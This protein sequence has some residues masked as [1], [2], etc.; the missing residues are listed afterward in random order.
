[1]DEEVDK[2]AL[3]SLANIIKNEHQDYTDEEKGAIRKGKEFY[4]KCK[5]DENFDDLKSPDERVKMKLVHVDGASSGTGVAT[6]VVDGSADECA[7][8]EIISLN[9]RNERKKAK[10]N[11]ITTMKVVNVNPHTLYYITTR[12]LGIPGFSPREGR[13]KVTWYKEDDGKV[14]IDVADT[15][16]LHKDFPVKA[17]NVVVKIHTVWVFEPLDS[18]GGVPQTSVTFMTKV[19]L[20]GIFFSSIVNKL[21]PRFLGV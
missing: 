18:I 5:E 3:A 2:A 14:I 19:D 1:R 12:K 9:S 11:G 10:M 6:T 17:G 13:S 20:G 16:E 7:A 4:E 21:A 15:K 8:N